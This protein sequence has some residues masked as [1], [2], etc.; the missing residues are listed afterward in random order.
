MRI[1]GVI[2][3]MVTPMHADGSLNLS[4]VCVLADHLIQAG[5][6]GL[7]PLGTAGE[8]FSLTRQEK[9]QMIAAVVKAAKGRV[10]VY[11]GV[12]GIATG[13]VI[14]TMKAVEQQG[15][16]AF[17]IVTP[18]YVPLSQAE[19][20]RHYE[21]I[22]AKTSLPIVLYNIPPRTGI[23]LEAHTVAELAQ[24][25]NIMGIK[26]S[27][28]SIEV[29]QSYL[30][31]VPTDFCVL[32]GNDAMILES[33]KR[34]AKGAI[35]ATSNAVPALVCGIYDSF[36]AGDLQKASQCQE[37]LKPLRECFA[38]GSVP[39]PTKAAA[40]WIGLAVGPT[41]MPVGELTKENQ[42]KLEQVME[43]H[44]FTYRI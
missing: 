36:L 20:L 34:R 16:D 23:A 32:A 44:Y 15:A 5:I 43:E 10:P 30:D 9:E 21:A 3:A 2:S 7:F 22:A 29:T 31:A 18:Y 11:A 19:L 6:D 1:E 40:R 8:F 33:L 42:A 35:A 12:G 41:R 17:S 27:S 38:L 37:A 25:D 26:D 13:E 24:I 4:Y 14:E 39:A 28:G